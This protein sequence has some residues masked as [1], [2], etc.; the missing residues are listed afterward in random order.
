MSRGAIMVGV[1]EG[2][3]VVV[4]VRLSNRS[5]PIVCGLLGV[6]RDSSGQAVRYYLNSL[7][8]H[9]EDRE[10]GYEGFRPS[11]AITTILTRVDV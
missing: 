4:V 7:I 6:D 2:E 1:A 8:H 3:D 5:S 9:G 10:A 11:G